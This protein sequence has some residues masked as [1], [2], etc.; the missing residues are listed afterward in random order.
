M[1][2]KH[3]VYAA[4]LA[5]LDE[6]VGRLLDTLRQLKLDRDTIVIL[7]SD[8]GGVDFPSGKSAS[9]SNQQ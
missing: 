1:I 9:S 6:N 2:H 3:A 7:T 8:N 4:M 5:S